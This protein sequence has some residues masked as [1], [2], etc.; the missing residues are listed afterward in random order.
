MGRVV[1]SGDAGADGAVPA[2]RDD[3]TGTSREDASPAGGTTVGVTAIGRL[4]G[5]STTDVIVAGSS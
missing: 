4:G 3:P 1:A 2:G 5:W